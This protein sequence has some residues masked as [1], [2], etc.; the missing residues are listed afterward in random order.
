MHYNYCRIHQTLRITPATAANLVTSP[1]SV[2]DI[3]ALDEKA[4][5]EAAPKKRGPYKKK[6]V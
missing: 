3:V 5:T 1:W 4:E 6:V 2:D